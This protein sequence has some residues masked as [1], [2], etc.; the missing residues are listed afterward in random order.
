MPP[1]PP[2]FPAKIYD[3]GGFEGKVSAIRGMCDHFTFL[4]ALSRA[5]TGNGAF[6][7]A[8]DTR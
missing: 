6:G 8:D 3:G 7:D 4:S 1:I 2:I 5:Q